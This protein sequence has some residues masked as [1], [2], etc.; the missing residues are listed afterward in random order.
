LP[1]ISI[2]I[3]NYKG[4]NRL[5]QC[6]DSLTVI[7]D[8][9]F[10]HEV[11]VV[12]NCSND[13]QVV[14]FQKIYPEFSFIINSGNS[15]FA[16]GCNLGAANSHGTFFLFL[17]PDT[18]VNADAL[19]LMIEE[20]RIRKA[21]SIISC[22]QIK[23]NGSE[24][25]PYGKFLSLST[26]TGWL[27]ALCKIFNG[28]QIKVFEQ[29]EDFIFP[30]WVS[31][32]VVMVSK[33]SF[34]GLGGWDDDFWMYFEDVD[35]CRRAKLNNGDIVILKK[36]VVEHNHGGSSRIN[37]QVTALTKTEVNISRH[38]YISKHETGMTAICMHT[39][40]IFDNILL[41]LLPAL[42]GVLLF[43][44]KDLNIIARIYIQLMSY[45]L[46]VLKSG[47]WLSKRSVNYPLNK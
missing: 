34:Q 24:D 39:I 4:W 18:I 14:N 27:R 42:A 11:I 6:L 17:N 43:F 41:G 45:Y 21:Y 32:S 31:G 1:D 38:V 5:S 12:D 44:I 10:S 16:N 36:A 35:F 29:T 7:K 23:E 15:G 37:K 47:T 19:F 28:S 33:T 25:R 26:L 20:A 9:R 2:I 30:D 40:L 13:G 22:R 3:V 46:N 8:S